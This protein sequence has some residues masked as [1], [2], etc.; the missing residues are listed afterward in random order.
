[1]DAYKNIFCRWFSCFVYKIN[2]VLVVLTRLC[3]TAG[4]VSRRTPCL[5]SDMRPDSVFAR[6]WQC[7]GATCC[8]RWGLC[9][10]CPG[11]LPWKESQLKCQ[12][13]IAMPVLTCMLTSG[14]R[15]CQRTRTWRT[16]KLYCGLGFSLTC[17]EIQPAVYKFGSGA[18]NRL[19]GQTGQ[20][21]N[22]S[23]VNFLLC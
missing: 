8:S 15:L 2:F 14:S 17:H 13:N 23:H 21:S 10:C 18:Q 5:G 11:W 6:L 19:T 1:M 7:W 16:C 4:G 22:S 3:T 9:E 20:F 12:L